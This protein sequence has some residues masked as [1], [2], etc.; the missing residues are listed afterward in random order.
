ML[1]WLLIN[2]GNYQSKRGASG[3]SVDGFAPATVRTMLLQ[4]DR[5]IP[6]M[7][8]DAESTQ[9]LSLLRD[10]ADK[11]QQAQFATTCDQ[12]KEASIILTSCSLE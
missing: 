2:L 12:L 7:D 3:M 4:V 10:C 11:A 8:E 5:D 9:V 6:T 1:Q